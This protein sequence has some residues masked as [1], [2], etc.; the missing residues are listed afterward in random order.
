MPLSAFRT[1]RNDSER[2]RNTSKLSGIPDK[3]V[4]LNLGN[5]HR[6]AITLQDQIEDLNLLMQGLMQRMGVVQ[7]D[8][9]GLVN[10][11]KV[12]EDCSVCTWV[13]V[14]VY[15]YYSLFLSLSLSLLSLNTKQALPSAN[16]V[17]DAQENAELSN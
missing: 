8:L 5:G 16:H 15:Q 7:E 10:R 2:S 9:H 6:G 17:F 4:T 11:N 1:Q 3:E 12:G 13:N 14:Y